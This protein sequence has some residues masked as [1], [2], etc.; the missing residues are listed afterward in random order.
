MQRALAVAVCLFSITSYANE[1]AYTAVRAIRPDGRSIALTN[2]TFERDVLRFTLNGTLHLLSPVEGKNPGAVFTGSGSYE[3]TPA[4]TRFEKARAAAPR[5]A[6]I[7][8]EALTRRID[9]FLGSRGYRAEAA[10][11]AP[12]PKGAAPA[13]TS[14]SPASATSEAPLDFVCEDDVRAALQAGRTLVISERAIV[15][16][17]ARDLGEQH[18]VFSIAPWRR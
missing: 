17:A 18:R 13:A 16:P 12:A 9:A 5:P 11:P 8:A 7:S 2:F 1:P 4:T 15:T 10:P 6:G 3:L 14:M